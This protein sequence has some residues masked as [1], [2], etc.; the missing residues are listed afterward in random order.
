M[1]I[2][3]RCNPAQKFVLT[4]WLKEFKKVVCVS[5]DSIGDCFALNEADV[6]LTTSSA[7]TDVAK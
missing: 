3:A 4:Q 5:G 7:G 2:V 6:G 1:K